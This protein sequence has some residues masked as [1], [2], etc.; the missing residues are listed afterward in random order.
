MMPEMPG[1]TDKKTLKVDVFVDNNHKT[2][3]V[4]Y[5]KREEDYKIDYLQEVKETSHAEIYKSAFS[6]ILHIKS[7]NEP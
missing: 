5:I 7:L 3:E 6:L 1:R 2:R 4:T